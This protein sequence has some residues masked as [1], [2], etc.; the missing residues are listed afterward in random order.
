MRDN[1]LVKAS[2]N[3][4]VLFCHQQRERLVTNRSLAG[5]C[6]SYYHKH[7]IIVIIC[8]WLL[9]CICIWYTWQSV[10]PLWSNPF[11]KWKY[12]IACF[13]NRHGFVP[14]NLQ[15]VVK[16]IYCHQRGHEFSNVRMY[17]IVDWSITSYDTFRARNKKVVVIT[18]C[19]LSFDNCIVKR[20]TFL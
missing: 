9:Y 7:I 12:G 19:G 14:R 17:Y 18:K 10:W 2:S 1:T 4:M 6:H 5:I 16:A 11:F 8:L 20:D 13:S 15:K 3:V